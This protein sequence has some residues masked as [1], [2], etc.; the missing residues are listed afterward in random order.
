MATQGT[1]ANAGAIEVWN[2]IA[3]DTFVRFRDVITKGFAAHSDAAIERR[4]PR[5][6]WRVLDV[7]CGF[8]D[9]AVKL[10]ELCGAGGECVGVDAA[11]RFIEASAATAKAAGCT[12]ARFL[13]ADVQ[14]D[15]LA[16]PYDLAFSRFGTM[17]FANPVAALRNL[18]RALKPGATLSMVVWRKKDEN[19]VYFLPEQRVLEIV[20]RP[21]KR[22]DQITCRPGP[23]SMS[24]SDVVSSQLLAAGFDRVTFERFDAEVCI[25]ASV[26]EAAA[27]SMSL[28]P[29]A[30]VLRLAREQGLDRRAEALGA[31][32]EL[33][34]G[35]QRP[36]GA[37]FGKSSS[38]LVSA[39]AG[40]PD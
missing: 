29:A 15:D 27:F 8:G 11:A 38:W 23:F 24:S 1:S 35:W 30:E 20:P 37:V 17:F 9:T 25:G 14:T 33:L 10:A 39:R 22:E 31:I 36:N 5:S 4:P 21:E 19:D 2:T 13:C 40:S 32:T 12:N 3:F 16:G 7:G 18:R 6:G 34:S 28:G 26:D